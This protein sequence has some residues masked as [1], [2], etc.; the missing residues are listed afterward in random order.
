MATENDR[1][2][3]LIADDIGECCTADVDRRLKELNT[4]QETAGLGA[5][6]D[7][8]R[9]FSALGNE[10]RYR[11]VRLLAAADGELCVCELDPLV[12]VSSSAIS[13]A[14]SNLTDAGLVERRKDGKW[15][16]Y[17]STPLAERLL[18]GIDVEQ[19]ETRA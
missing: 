18:D 17:R 19:E 1:L 16:Y 15:R 7:D 13:H 10:T 9:T 14:L 2:R 6:Y 12:D 5:V 4:I 8:V 3:R 11:I